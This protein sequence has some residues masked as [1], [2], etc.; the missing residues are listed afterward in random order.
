MGLFEE[1][2]RHLDRQ[3]M[4]SSWNSGNTLDE[5]QTED[6]RRIQRNAAEKKK[7]KQNNTQ[8][9]KNSSWF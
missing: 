2:R 8:A 3:P 1:E 4:N 5:Q 6:L 7:K 9:K